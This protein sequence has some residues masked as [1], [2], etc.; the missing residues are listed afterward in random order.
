MNKVFIIARKEFLE[1]LKTKAFLFSVVVVPLILGV[2]MKVGGGLKKRIDAGPQPPRTVAMIDLSGEF[3][4]ELKVLFQQHNTSSSNRRI[5]LE[6][7]SPEHSGE[8]E[9]EKL[10]GRIREH[11][12]DGLLWI[13][14]DVLESGGERPRYY[15]LQDSIAEQETYQ[16]VRRLLNDAV[17]SRRCERRNLSKALVDEIRRFLPVDQLDVRSDTGSQSQG[18]FPFRMMVPFFF[19]FLM[20]MG[21]FGVNQQMLTSVIEEKSSRVVEVLLSAVTPFE[22]MSG[23]ILGL[24]GAGLVAV[25]LWAVVAVFA[26]LGWGL[27][28]VFEVTQA[29]YFI[30]YYVLGFLLLSSIFAAIGSAC[31]SLKESQSMVLPVSLTFVLPLMGWIYIAQYPDSW[32]TVLLSMLPPFSPLIMMIRLAVR[33]DLPLYQIIPSI[34]LLA[35]ATLG[36]LWASSRIFRIGILMYGKPPKLREL[37]RWIHAR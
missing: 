11:Q 35:V 30:I 28:S 5:L 18:G 6:P 16:A 2:L 12:L 15:L 22:F 13:P 14:P 24:G 23:K 9:V 34:V 25:A 29:V 33:P 8:A 27:G 17:V 20:F 4:A 31:N 19:M 1:T 7:V 26:A 10:K 36:V 32:P 37:L 3:Q 21:I